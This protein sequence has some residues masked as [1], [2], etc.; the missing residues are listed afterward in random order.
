MRFARLSIS[1]GL[2]CIAIS[3]LERGNLNVHL[4]PGVIIDGI[5]GEPT[6]KIPKGSCEARRAA[7][8]QEARKGRVPGNSH[9]K[10]KEASTRV[11]PT[12][13][14]RTPC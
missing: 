5:A 12:F 9:Q 13:S 1:H 14:S 8:W 11:A 7:V 2:L 6:L 4:P 10:S 3:K